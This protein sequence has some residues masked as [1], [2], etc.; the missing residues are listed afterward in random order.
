M[1]A[2]GGAAQSTNA[3]PMEWRLLSCAGHWPPSFNVW[4]AVFPTVPAAESPDRYSLYWDR[5]WRML[6]PSLCFFSAAWTLSI[7]LIITGTFSIA[8]RVPFLNI[9]VFIRLR[10]TQNRYVW[11]LVAIRIPLSRKQ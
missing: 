5:S 11:I 3:T 7:S 10:A 2:R 1:K 8:I 4:P 6:L 9:F